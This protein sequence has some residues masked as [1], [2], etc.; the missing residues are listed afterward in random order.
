MKKFIENFITFTIIL[1]IAQTIIEEIAVVSAFSTSF[2]HA[3]LVS[4]FIFDLIFSVEF[5]FRFFYAARNKKTKKYLSSELGWIDFASSIP[6]LF[7]NSGPMLYFLFKS[8]D[9]VGA[10]GII[11][12][13]NLLKVVKIVRVT[14]ILRMMRFLKLLKNLNFLKSKITQ[15]HMNF[16]ISSVISFIILSVITVNLTGLWGSSDLK[17]IKEKNFQTVFDETMQ[18]SILYSKDFNE[19]M[20]KVLEKDKTI[21]ILEFDK[22]TVFEKKIDASLIEMQNINSFQYQRFNIYYIDYEGMSLESRF[23]LVIII[24]ILFVLTGL[25]VFYSKKFALDVSDTIQVVEKGLT[26]PN[27]FFRLKENTETENESE[28]L[29]K[30]YNEIWLPLKMKY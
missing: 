11:G 16:I 25:L 5:G 23:N 10:V 21:L 12:V 26:D 13:L 1:V 9:S 15:Q 2:K 6:L 8:G 29:T 27:Y 14:R 22:Q 4:G 19:M 3:L 28:K 24:T 30:A 20:T 7:L 18:L 17:E